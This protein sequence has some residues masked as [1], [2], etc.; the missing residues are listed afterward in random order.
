M[1]IITRR[2]VL[3]FGAGAAI[4]GAFAALAAIAP[5]MVSAHEVYVLTPGQISSALAAPSFSLF[6]VARDNLGEFAFWAFIGVLTVFCVFWISTLR[7]LERHLDPMFI[8]IR[9][10]A[11]LI[12][13]LT[14]GI[15]FI[16]SAYYQATFGPELPIAANFGP[17]AG[18]VAVI[19]IVIGFMVIFGLYARL[20]ALA[21]LVIYAATV[22]QHGW[23][24][25]TYVNYLGEIIVI[26]ILGSHSYSLDSL[27]ARRRK[28]APGP[29]S[30]VARIKGYLAPRSLAILRVLFGIALIYASAFAKILHNSLA[31]DTVTK[32]HLDRLLGFEPHFLVLGAAIVEIL[33]G[34][35]F[36]LGI[37]IRFTSL[38]FLF[39]LCLSLWFFGEVVWPHLILIGIPIAYLFY[40]YDEYSVEGYFFRSKKYE[41]VL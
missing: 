36:I 18:L 19:L 25:L 35:F 40:G 23:Y 10:Y 9:K 6:D 11:T 13:R 26:L 38:F 22:Y 17:Y 8:K 1:R 15:S 37:E 39:W 27:I 20:A 32:Y 4:V 41:P 33:I 31:L 34:L 2:S 7:F 5:A 29:S 30:L 21:G 14:I 28:A 24:M 12:A 16:A 3:S